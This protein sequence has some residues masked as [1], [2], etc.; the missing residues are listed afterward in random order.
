MQNHDDANHQEWDL[1]DGSAMSPAKQRADSSNAQ[2]IKWGV[3]I[4]QIN[5]R[6]V[7]VG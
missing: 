7:G 1:Q 3:V 5:S 2:Q 6:I 4:N